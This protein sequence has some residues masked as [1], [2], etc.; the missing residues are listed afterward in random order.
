MKGKK[1]SER[2]GEVNRIEVKAELIHKKQTPNSIP[3]SLTSSLPLT[4]SGNTSGS[5]SSMTA[6]VNPKTDLPSIVHLL[7]LAPHELSILWLSSF[8]RDQSHGHLPD[9]LVMPGEE[10]RGA[11]APA[12]LE[13]EEYSLI[14]P[15]VELRQ[16]NQVICR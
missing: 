16:K 13:V 14:S 1:G 11:G 7:F 8:A 4:S 10:D 15:K 6:F 12:G 9:P 5:G 3:L 2:S